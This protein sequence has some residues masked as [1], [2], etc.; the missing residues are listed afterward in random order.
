MSIRNSVFFS[1]VC[2][3][4]RGHGRWFTWKKD[5]REGGW[6]FNFKLFNYKFILVCFDI[7]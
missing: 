2:P 4:Y 5:R 7:L 6:N 1:F 3:P